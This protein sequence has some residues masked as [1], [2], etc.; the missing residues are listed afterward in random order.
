MA[1]NIRTLGVKGSSLLTEF[2]RRGKRLFTFEDAARVYG[3][4][5]G[6]LSKLLFTLV[7]RHWLQPRPAFTAVADNT[8]EIGSITYLCA[9][10]VCC[11]VEPVG[12]T[13]HPLKF[14]Q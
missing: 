9:S 12:A 14:A 6:G 5:N 8:S 10:L 3:G 4:T 1:Q 2:S 7:K 11:H 13:F